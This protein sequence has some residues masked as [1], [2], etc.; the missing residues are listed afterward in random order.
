MP[1]MELS[2]ILERVAAGEISAAGAERLLS[3]D[4]MMAEVA[5][6]CLDLDRARR[7]GPGRS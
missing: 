3:E 2:K 7:C 5:D 4:G 1:P 6:A